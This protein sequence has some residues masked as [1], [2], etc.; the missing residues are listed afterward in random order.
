MRLQEVLAALNL[1][2]VKTIDRSHRHYLVR[3][4]DGNLYI[5]IVT[6]RVLRHPKALGINYDNEMF[7][8]KKFYIDYYLRKGDYA[9]VIWLY[10]G[11]AYIAKAREIRET[12]GILGS[13]IKRGFEVICHYPVS[14]CKRIPLN[15]GLRKFMSSGSR[16][17]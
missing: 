16:C 8:I 7:G 10:N 4:G 14:A 3:D 2:Y 5:V 6:N 1:Q 11:D 17:W 12:I 9:G 13:C 15:E